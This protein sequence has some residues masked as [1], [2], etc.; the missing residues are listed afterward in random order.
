MATRKM[1]VTRS[2]THAVSYSLILPST[3]IPA[4][5]KSRQVDDYTK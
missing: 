5:P 3:A 2:V 1:T 4:K